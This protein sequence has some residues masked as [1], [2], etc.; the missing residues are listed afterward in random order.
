MG[1]IIQRIARCAGN[2]CRRLIHD[3]VYRVGASV[4]CYLKVD[5]EAGLVV[6]DGKTGVRRFAKKPGYGTVDLSN[7]ND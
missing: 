2:H 7:G 6:I 5:I 3:I 1:P 4:I